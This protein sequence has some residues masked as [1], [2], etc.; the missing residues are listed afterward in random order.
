MLYTPLTHPTL[1]QVLA[2]T[3]H[4]SKVLIADG[5]YP[6]ALHTHAD[7]ERVYLNICP[8]L[9]SVTD[10]LSV[11][12]KTAPIEAASIML[13]D[14]ESEPDIYADFYR[15]LPT[16]TLQPVERFAFYTLAR[17]HDVVLAIA[18][19]EQRLYANIL[20]TIGV[21]QPT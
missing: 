9:V 8:G 3:G 14:D 19:G 12:S 7:A 16:A 5:N 2:M 15:I 20:L 4:G 18:T 6:L 10:M 11:I 1:L 21:V 17:Q 13:C